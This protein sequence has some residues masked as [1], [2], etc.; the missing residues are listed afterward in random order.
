ML[1]KFHRW[2]YFHG[3]WIPNNKF[4]LCFHCTNTLVLKFTL[5]P[6]CL[7]FKLLFLVLNCHFG[8]KFKMMTSIKFNDSIQTSLISMYTHYNQVDMIGL[9][10][11][12]LFL[13]K[14]HLLYVFVPVNLFTEIDCDIMKVG[15]RHHL[16]HHK[17]GEFFWGI[18]NQK[19][20]A[21]VLHAVFL[22][23][24]IGGDKNLKC[25]YKKVI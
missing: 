21:N 3:I 5:F 7:V 4:V 18:L 12:L 13:W 16:W 20:Q 23:Y 24:F 25:Y 14:I 6:C 10:R 11:N 17:P 2:T 19:S 8:V 1:N 15:H 9:G 22:Y